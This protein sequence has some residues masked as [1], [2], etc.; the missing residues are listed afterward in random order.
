MDFAELSALAGGHAEARAIQVA[1]KLGVF[2]ALAHEELDEQRLA[3]AIGCATQPTGLLANALAAM[4][5]LEKQSAR[6]RLTDAARRFLVESSDQYLGGMILFDEKLFETW[7]RL[8]ET[9]RTGAPARMPDMF[10]ERAD[11]TERFVRAMDS[12]VRARGD[13]RHLGETLDLS[14]VAFM[15]DLGG[16]PATYLLE[17]ARRWPRLRTAVYDLPATLEVTRK[18]LARE[19]PDLRE[20][21]SLINVNYLAQELPGGCD[22]LFLSN[23]IHSENSATNRELMGKCYRALNSGG[24]LLIKDHVMNHDLTAPRAGA[25]FSLYLMLATW[26]RDYGFDEIAG[27]LAEA[28]FIAIEQQALPSPPFSSSLVIARRP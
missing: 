18:L 15:A 27:W 14:G 28:G 7:G 10:Q 4:E 6:Y 22:A 25:I 23:I 17:F 11:E 8:E 9:I 21:I 13:A 20:R 12:L 2:E 16:G 26:G 24:R 3:S 5:L 19:P 1:L